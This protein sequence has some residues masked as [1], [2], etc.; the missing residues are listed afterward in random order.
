MNR[1]MVAIALALLLPLQ[2]V[3]L[4]PVAAAIGSEAG[5][6][7]DCGSRD[8][9]S[10]QECPC[11]PEGAT[12]MTGCLTLCAVAVAA[13]GAAVLFPSNV[14]PSVAPVFS[15]HGGYSRSDIPPNPPP[16]R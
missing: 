4:S 6:M 3:A 14:T 15:A 5:P 13:L 11:C 9:P 1:R 7:Q 12:S 16:I 2:A 10:P 8:A